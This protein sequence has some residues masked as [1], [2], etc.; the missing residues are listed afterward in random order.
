MLP[1]SWKRIC[2]PIHTLRTQPVIAVINDDVEEVPKA[3]VVKAMN[4]PVDDHIFIRDIKKHVSDH[5]ARYKWLRGGV[6]V[7]DVIPK[8]AS[9]KILRRHLRDRDR[10]A[11]VKTKTKA[12]PKL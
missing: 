11:K 7:I 10:G 12:R 3:Y 6:E 2:L 5:K 4:A 8:T 1:L 9:G